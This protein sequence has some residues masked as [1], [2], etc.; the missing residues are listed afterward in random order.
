M[1]SYT[2]PLGKVQTPPPRVHRIEDIS[3]NPPLF[4]LC[5]CGWR[6]EVQN[7]AQLVVVWKQH[8]ADT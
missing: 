6:A 1:T 2:Y 4:V 3:H 7:V 5:T 8:K